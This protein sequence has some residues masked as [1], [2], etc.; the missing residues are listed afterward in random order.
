IKNTNMSKLFFSAIALCF[1][2][3]TSLYAQKS[4]WNTKD[5][6][7]GQKPPGDTP[8]VFGAGMLAKADTFA[9]DRVAFSDDGTE[10]YYPS[11]DTWFSSLNGKVRYMKFENGKWNGPFVLN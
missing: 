7:L 8:E 6:Y 9:F 3:S 4:I 2:I 11:N 10:F 5:A 1:V